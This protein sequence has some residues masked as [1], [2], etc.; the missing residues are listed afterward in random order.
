MIFTLIFDD[1]KI[2]FHNQAIKCLY[3]SHPNIFHLIKI[4]IK[5]E[6]FDIVY[7]IYKNEKFW[8]HSLQNKKNFF[9]AKKL[10]EYQWRVISRTECII[11]IFSFKYFIQNNSYSYLQVQW[12]KPLK[13]I[14]N[15]GE[16][17]VSDQ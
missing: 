11:Q 2:L 12:I 15:I 10:S 13:C 8:K 4:L 6:Q 1:V 17:Q 5:N 16:T 9:L 14:Y 7:Y 3:K